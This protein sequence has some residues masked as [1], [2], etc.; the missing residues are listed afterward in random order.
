MSGNET[1]MNCYKD[2]FDT[3]LLNSRQQTALT[4]VNLLTMI[5]NVIGNVLV[6]YIVIKTGQISQITSKLV[7][8]LSASNLLLALFC[9]SLLT[10]LFYAT[11]CSFVEVY[12]FFS[13]FLLHTS[14]YTIAMI[15]VDRYLRIRFYAIFKT[16]W[17]TKKVLKL[18]LILFGLALF[19]AVI[20]AAGL[21]LGKEQFVMPFYI[22]VDAIVIGTIILLQILTIQTS[23]AVHKE[24]TIVT[25]ERINK[26][27]TKLSIR[28]MLL[29]CFF[30][31]PHLIIYTAREVIP[32]QLIY[33]RKST[34]EFVS[35]ISLVWAY[36]NSFCNAVLFL[37]TNVKA[38]RFLR[39]CLQQ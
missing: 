10:A 33:F 4:V 30:I 18:T 36:M 7:L 21:L 24:S 25:S 12:A 22:T 28:I 34:V 31:T 11:H 26:K 20:I 39:N 13:V 37:M 8:M 5:G 15:G 35:M 6:I 32:Y 3:S 2:I 16:I 19:Q 38:K 17:T 23:N 27:I 9:Q 1:S 14:G 29:L